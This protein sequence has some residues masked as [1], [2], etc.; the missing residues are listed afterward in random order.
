MIAIPTY[1]YDPHSVW[2]RNQ[3]GDLSLTDPTTLI[4]IGVAG[5][6]LYAYSKKR[7]KG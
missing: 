7:R 5:Y 1:P 3:L 4:M 6:L 2:N